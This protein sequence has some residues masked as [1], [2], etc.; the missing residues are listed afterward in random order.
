WQRRLTPNLSGLPRLFGAK[1]RF[2][3]N[4]FFSASMN[5]RT[6]GVQ[7]ANKIRLSPTN[8]SRK[9]VIPNYLVDLPSLSFFLVSFRSSLLGLHLV[10][11]LESLWAATQHLCLHSCLSALAFWQQVN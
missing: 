4:F 1:V 9:W 7:A 11:D 8:A 3:V 2:L 6:H 10:H 5:I